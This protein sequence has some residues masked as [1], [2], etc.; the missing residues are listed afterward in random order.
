MKKRSSI[1]CPDI[2]GFSTGEKNTRNEGHQFWQQDNHPVEISNQKMKQQKLNYL[3][4]NPV[5]AGIVRNTERYIYSSA[6]DY[7]TGKEGLIRLEI[8]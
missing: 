3:H 6:N 2:S 8:L 5:R 7:Y 1:V 4:E